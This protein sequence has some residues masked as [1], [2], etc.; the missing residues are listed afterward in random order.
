[1]IVP[2]LINLVVAPMAVGASRAAAKERGVKDFFHH[3]V[4]VYAS[5][6]HVELVKEAL[7]RVAAFFGDDWPKYK[8]N[9]KRVILDP[10]QH[11]NLWFGQRSVVI[12]ESDEN[13]LRSINHM[14]AW[15]IAD[16]Q[17]IQY[18][19]ERHAL[20]IIW[21]KRLMDAANASGKVALDRFVA[22][23]TSG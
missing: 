15:L 11:T 13:R 4:A 1:M 10:D 14:A 12:K 20:K 19:K 17:R 2:S 9:L 5:D 3:G 6:E 8:K 18:L 23:K 22:Q 16:Y 7:D 21:S